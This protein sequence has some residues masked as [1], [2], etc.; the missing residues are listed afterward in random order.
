MAFWQVF[1]ALSAVPPALGAGLDKFFMTR[2]ER[3]RWYDRLLKCWLLVDES[4]LLRLPSVAAEGFARSIDSV[5]GPPRLSR[6]FVVRSAIFS[7]CATVACVAAGRA[8]DYGLIES[9]RTHASRPLTYLFLFFPI[10]AAANYPFDLAAVLTSRWVLGRIRACSGIVGIFWVAINLSMA[11]VMAWTCAAMVVPG[12]ILVGLEHFTNYGDLILRMAWYPR[13]LIQNF[14]SY[15]S[16]KYLLLS[17]SM[18]VPIAVLALVLLML[19][20]AKLALEVAKRMLQVLLEDNKPDQLPV[21]AAAGFL[22][23]IANVIVTAVV[24]V[25]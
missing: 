6:R 19:C 13:W 14:Q 11:L 20:I 23:S 15:H 10:L 18:L 21:L 25:A 17:A 2:G 7:F 16:H 24:K 4:R 8:W 3:A 5:L 12:R 9:T 1:I 22:V